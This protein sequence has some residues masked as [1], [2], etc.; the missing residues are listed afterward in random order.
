MEQHDWTYWAFVGSCVALAIFIRIRK[1]G[2]LRRLRPGTLWIIPMVFILL[3]SMVLWQYPPSGL[4]W[5]WIAIG[6]AA[7]AGIGWWRATYIE[8]SVDPETGQLNQRSS[9]GTFIVIGVIMLVQWLLRWVV[10]L[11]DTQ[12]HFGAILISD[13]FIAMAVGALSAYRLEIFLRAR[14]LSVATQPHA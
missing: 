4:E 14:H 1:V 12:L 10:M 5:L 2:K 6:C 3:A 13:I 8:I 9:W 7:G 11:G